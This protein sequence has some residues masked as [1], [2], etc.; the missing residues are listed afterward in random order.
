[1][2]CACEITFF[3]NNPNIG[4][5]RNARSQFNSDFLRVIKD[6]RNHT[7]YVDEAADMIRVSRETDTADTIQVMQNLKDLRLGDRISLPCHMVPYGLNLR[8]FGRSAEVENV[9][10]I[11]DPQETTNHLRV[12]PI[13]GLGGVGKTQLVLHYANTSRKLYDVIIW[14]PSEPQIKLTQA[15]SSFARRL[16]LPNAE[17]IED[18]YG[19]TQKI[20][21]WLNTSGHSFLLVFDNVDQ[22]EILDQI[23]PTSEKGSIVITTRSTAVASRRATNIMHLESFKGAAGPEALY[24]LTGITPANEADASV[25]E[26]ICHLVGGLRLAL[27]QISEFIRDRRLTYQKFLPIYEKSAE[28]IYARGRRQPSITRLSAPCGTCLSK[29]PRRSR[30]YF[31]TCCRSLT[32]TR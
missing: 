7:R 1:V 5:S 32:Q 12:L 11:L 8:F 31:R 13:H 17:S 26:Q 2:F 4:K 23:W 29:N 28:K 3:R 9:K 18:D 15:L 27:V 16:G 25:A 30:A 22:A 19:S 20:R 24:S 10:N 14:I 6:L 21:D